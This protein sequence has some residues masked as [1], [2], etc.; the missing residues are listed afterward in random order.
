MKF[1]KQKEQETAGY[2]DSHDFKGDKRKYEMFREQLQSKF[3]L[4]YNTIQNAPQLFLM[5]KNMVLPTELE[6]DDVA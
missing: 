6:S 3:K 1:K 2:Y 4:N 5:E